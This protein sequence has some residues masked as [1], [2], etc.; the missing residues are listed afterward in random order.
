MNQ[1]QLRL[2][3]WIRR[4]RHFNRHLYMALWALATVLVAFFAFGIAWVMSMA[5]FAWK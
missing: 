1:K 2:Y 3:Q 5:F 4:T